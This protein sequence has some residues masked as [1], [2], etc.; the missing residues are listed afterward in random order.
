[1]GHL[2]EIKKTWWEHFVIT[3]KFI[4]KLIIHSFFPNLFVTSS[5]ND[6]VKKPK[7]KK[8]VKVTFVPNVEPTTVLP[9]TPE[10]REKK[11]LVY[12][13]RNS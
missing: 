8:E 7:P 1:M 2:N 4:L 5:L 3:W 6:V 13:S 10:V 9:P 12:T 11:V